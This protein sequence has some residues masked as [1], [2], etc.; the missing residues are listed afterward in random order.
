M[1]KETS[2]SGPKE[3]ETKENRDDASAN[4]GKVPMQPNIEMCL[5]GFTEQQGFRKSVSGVP[6][7]PTK[8][9]PTFGRSEH[10]NDPRLDR[11]NHQS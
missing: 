10:S 1:G 4:D 5:T 11:R 7:R 6:G 3:E 9:T 2:H 8:Y